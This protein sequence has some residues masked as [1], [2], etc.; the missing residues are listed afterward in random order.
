M[1]KLTELPV[2]KSNCILDSSIWKLTWPKPSSIEG[3]P[4]PGWSILMCFLLQEKPV[5]KCEPGDC[6]QRKV[7]ATNEQE[8]QGREELP[9][10]PAFT[11]WAHGL[12]LCKLWCSS[13]TTVTLH[14]I[15]KTLIYWLPRC[16]INLQNSP[17]SAVD[18]NTHPILLRSALS[19][20][21]HV[22]NGKTLFNP[23]LLA[24]SL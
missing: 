15:S 19:K 5:L 8:Y 23:D 12:Q 3:E 17:S 13:H 9:L 24:L 4:T 22:I 20:I 10:P 21:V 7:T 2:S 16:L 6:W 18:S 14:S 1:S 11:I